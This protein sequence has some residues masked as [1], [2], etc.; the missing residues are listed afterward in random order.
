MAY[1]ITFDDLCPEWTT[2]PEENLSF[3]KFAERKFNEILFKQ[4][5][6]YLK[7]LLNEMSIAAPFPEGLGWWIETVDLPWDVENF[8]SFGLYNID[9]PQNRRFINGLSPIAVLD[10]NVM[11]DLT[12]Y[13]LDHAI[14]IGGPE[15]AQNFFDFPWLHNSGLYL[16]GDKNY[17]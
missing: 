12:Q 15:F 6:L 14:M 9:I 17:E 7:D 2:D 3:L 10:F 5:Y 16:E 4:G 11:G 8:I 13:F 1:R